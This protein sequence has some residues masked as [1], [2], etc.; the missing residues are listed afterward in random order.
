MAR[1]ER[2]TCVKLEGTLMS[3]DHLQRILDGTAEGVS[4]QEYGLAPGEKI[5]EAISREWEKA[6]RHWQAFRK[7]LLDIPS[8]D[9]ATSLTRERWLLPLFSIL[10]YGRLQA[11][12]G[13]QAGGQEYP[14]SHHF[15]MSPLHLLGCHVR[16]DQKTAGLRGAARVSPHG[17]VQEY[18]N[19]SDEDLW[20]IVTNGETLRLLRDN[21]HV[22]RMSYIEFDLLAMMET[23]AYGDFAVMWMLLHATRMEAR[24]DRAENCLLETWA[25]QSRDSGVR[26]LDDLRSGVEAALRALGTGFLQEASNAA[27]RAGLQEGR[28]SAQ[29][30]LNQLM[31]LVYRLIFLFVAED[32]GIIPSSSPELM[33]GRER[34]L[35]WYSLAALRRA[36]RRANDTRHVDRWEGLKTVM[37]LLQEGSDSLALPALGSFLWSRDALP[38]LMGANLSNDALMNALRQLCFTTAAG[39]TRVAVDWKNM[40]S[41]ELG[42]IYESLLELIPSVSVGAD[43]PFLL[44]A[45]AGN[46]RKGTGSYYT[47]S[48]LISSLLDTALD[49]VIRDAV[50]GKTAKDAIAALL[51]LKVCDPSCG[52]GHF[53]VG[54][55]HRIARRLA[56]LETGEEEPSPEALRSALRRVIARCVY[57]VDLNPMSVELCKVA[58]WMESL[59]PGKPLS[60]LDHHIKCGNSLVGAVPALIGEGIPDEAFNAVTGDDKEL[61]KIFKRTNRQR[62]TASA[63]AQIGFLT[64]FNLGIPQEEWDDIADYARMVAAGEESSLAEVR[65]MERDYLSLRGTEG[66]RHAKL[67][68]DAWCA[69]FTQEKVPEKRN[70]I[71]DGSRFDAVRSAPGKVSAELRAEIASQADAYRFCHWHLEFP[72]V[73]FSLKREDTHPWGIGGG[74]DAVLGNPPWDKVKMEEVPWFTQHD[75]A[76]ATAGTAA[77]R[78][79]KIADLKHTNPRLLA[80]FEEDKR[81]IENES[82]F[83]RVSGLYPLSAVGDVNTYAV[84]T[85]LNRNLTAPAG[86][87]GFIVPTGIATDKGTSALFGDLAGKDRID[88]LYSFDNRLQIFPGVHSSYRFCLLTL[89][90]ALL[91]GKASDYAFFLEKTDDLKERE[92]HFGMTGDELRLFNPNTGNCPTFRN[93]RDKQIA[94]KVYRN[95][96]VLMREARE[97]IPEENPWGIEYRRMFDMSNDSDKFWTR[98]RLQAA[99]YVPTANRWRKGKNWMLPLYEG[100]MIYLFDHRY[101]TYAGATQTQLNSG[102]LPKLTDEEHGDPWKLPMPQYWVDKKEAINK[103]SEAALAVISFRDIT[104]ATNQRTMVTCVAPYGAFGNKAPILVPQVENQQNLLVCTMSSLMFDFIARMSVGGTNMNLYILKQLPVLSLHTI[105]THNALHNMLFLCSLEL[106][107]TSW[108]LY[109]WALKDLGMNIPP[110]RWDPERRHKLE[111]LLN[112]IAAWLYG[113]DEQDLDYILDTFPGLRSDEIQQYGSYRMKEEIL[114]CFTIVRRLSQGQPSGLEG[115]LTPAPG[116]ASRRYP[117]P[118]RAEAEEKMPWID[119][120]SLPNG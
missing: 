86:R 116:D 26:A 32:R 39:G 27:L 115:F 37:P 72:E 1:I 24:E 30:Y 3:H 94:D 55:A 110:Y 74:F 98:E 35:A 16:L 73:F 21:A 111:A 64:A 108:D 53:L 42:S 109:P 17:L 20:G 31:R 52:S 69:A 81:R 80:L 25:R 47:P 9:P 48:A 95:C 65:A 18:L 85:E 79:E 75:P 114:E 11:A 7:S 22:A 100:K 117:F 43:E 60:F 40:G 14:I 103:L 56:V 13:L 63:S 15:S 99:G 66:W 89:R 6:I 91:R 34:Y 104:N 23:S 10:G 46:E 29:D 45:Q 84:F 54:A 92:R 77:Q 51:N 107:Y 102:Q 28:L 120:T 105:C 119:W 4:S 36:R 118:G 38:D 71:L 58:L 19:R 88:S 61:C 59:E 67:V 87:A 68:A 113:V 96:P 44:I 2:F 83:L 78:K 90:G 76:I 5:N 50:Q 97:G 93:A 57:G 62:R 106:L 49:P 70:L 33:E 8:D 82:K 101:A 41:E 12:R 112:A